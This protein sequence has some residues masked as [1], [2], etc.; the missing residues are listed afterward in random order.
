MSTGPPAMFRQL[1]A[2][3]LNR[4]TDRMKVSSAPTGL[5]YESRRGESNSYA[6][7]HDVLSIA[8]LPI[9][10]LRVSGSVDDS[11]WVE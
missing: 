4:V 7:G 5:Q 9:P 1:Q 10:S 8:C 6:K 11:E 2:P 3:E